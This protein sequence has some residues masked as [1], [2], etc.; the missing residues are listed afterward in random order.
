MYIYIYTQRIYIY[1]LYIN[2]SN[3][4]ELDSW[5]SIVSTHW[6]F[7][8]PRN[9]ALMSL[10]YQWSHQKYDDIFD[11]VWYSQAYIW[12]NYNIS[13]TW[14]K[15]IW[16]WFPLITMIPVRSQW[17]RYN[18]R[19]YM[20]QVT[21]GSSFWPAGTLRWPARSTRHPRDIRHKD[22]HLCQTG[23]RSDGWDPISSVFRAVPC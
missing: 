18:L 9:S 22:T 14:I 10:V 5:I 13:L 21:Q 7:L 15:A 19:R 6:R 20:T 4:G 23:A 2:K 1:I 8:H 16:G 3:H 17:G 11:V 12:V